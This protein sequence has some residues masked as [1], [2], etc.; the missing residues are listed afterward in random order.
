MGKL[1]NEAQIGLVYL[2]GEAC[3][4][5]DQC[6]W[7]AFVFFLSIGKLSDDHW[8]ILITDFEEEVVGANML[9]SD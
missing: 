5:H 4:P 7:R 3:A 6:Y 2:L 1:L 8:D 9:L